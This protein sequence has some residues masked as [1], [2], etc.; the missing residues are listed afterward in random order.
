MRRLIASLPKLTA[1][2]KALVREDMRHDP[3]RGWLAAMII[4]D[5][6]ILVA[7]VLEEP[8]VTRYSSDA[9]ADAL[10]WAIPSSC[11]LEAVD[12]ACS[13][14]EGPPGAR[15]A[16]RQRD[17]DDRPIDETVARL[18]A[19]AFERYG[20]GRG[21]AARL[22]FGDCLSYAVAKALDAPLLF[23]GGDFALTDVAAAL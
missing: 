19:D 15:W 17:P 22:N 9:I 23:K 3:R 14:G 20:R 13:H 4:V 5:T 11:Y 10:D 8:D 6:S 16:A 1:E 12:G 21:H 2:E 18:A 7:I